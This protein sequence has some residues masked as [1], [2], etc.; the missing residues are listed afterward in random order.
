M[1]AVHFGIDVGGTNIKI[2]AFREDAQLLKKWMIPTDLS[3]NGRNILPDIANEIHHYLITSDYALR[4]IGIG[5]PGPVD[6]NGFIEKCVDLFWYNVNPVAVLS[7]EFPEAYIA[8]ANDAN[9]AAIGE[10]WYGAGEKYS[11]MMLITLGTG[12]GGGIILDGKI[13]LGAHGLG[14]E[15]GHIAIVPNEEKRCN[16]GNRGCIDQVASATGIV[17]IMKNILKLREKAP[18]YSCQLKS[19]QDFSAKDVVDLAKAG[20][21]SALD[22][23]QYC[24]EQLGRGMAIFSHAVDPE[25]YVIGGG[26]S[27]AGEIILEPIRKSYNQNIFLVQKGAEI[28]LS[29]LRNDAGIIGAFALAMRHTQYL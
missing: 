23:I 21:P 15:I 9:A 12:V 6:Q 7:K 3:D 29:T 25:V 19:G 10:Y 22:C 14:G 20:D 27:E 24:M 28:K 1:T 5:I 4:T 26:V 13:L 2:G 11:S 8:V 17:R 18:K 16:C